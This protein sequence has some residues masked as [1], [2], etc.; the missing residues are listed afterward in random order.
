M[1]QNPAGE[2]DSRVASQ[3]SFLHKNWRYITGLTKDPRW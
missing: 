2:C 1:E 3:I